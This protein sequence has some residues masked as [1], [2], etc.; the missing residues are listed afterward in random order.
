MITDNICHPERDYQL[1]INSANAA[2]SIPKWDYS[3]KPPMAA[4]VNIG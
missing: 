3:D 1:K 4:V 2:I